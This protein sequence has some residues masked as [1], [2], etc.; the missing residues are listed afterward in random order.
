MVTAS[1]RL[2]SNILVE[3][4]LRDRNN[5]F[6][7]MVPIARMSQ[8]DKYQDGASQISIFVGS[9]VSFSGGRNIPFQIE[10]V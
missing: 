2:C 10:R 9:V 8:P 1:D 5:R 3:V 4:M 7:F 6:P